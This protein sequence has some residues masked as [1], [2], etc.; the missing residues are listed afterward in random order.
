[1]QIDL[2]VTEL[3]A[4]RLCHDLVG[5]IGAVSNG[6]EL[7]AD[8]SFGMADDALALAS[9]SAGQ[10]THLLQFYR[11]AYG[12][13]GNRQGSDLR[14]LRELAA[15]FLAHSKAKLDWPAD[16]MP[17]DVPDG[18]GKLILNMIALALE[19]LPRGG[20]IG[21]SAKSAP[22][23]LEIE[24]KAVGT[25]AGLRPECQAALAPDVPLDDLTPR[26]V[27]GYFTRV[28]AQTLGAGLSVEPAGPGYLRLASSPKS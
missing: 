8:E 10:A 12:M 16:G 5:P 28:V 18:A 9:N 17:A 24:I 20:T 7:M 3:L 13:A 15:N 14:P 2:K 25:D 23:G 4:S 11:L 21:V 27:H 1:M 26:N 19:A 6:L 22:G